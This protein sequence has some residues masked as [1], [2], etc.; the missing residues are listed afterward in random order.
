MQALGLIENEETYLKLIEAYSEKHRY[1]HTSCHIKA[2]LDHL[3]RVNHLADNPQEIEL[4]LWFHDAV[5]KPY[6]STNELDSA[7]WA[8]QFLSENK[9]D[10]ATCERVY[11]LIMVTLHNGKINTSDEELM[12]DIDLSILGSSSIVYQVFEQ[13]V[14][15]EYRWVPYFLYRKKRK[16]ILQGFLDQSKVYQ[17]D[18][19]NGLFEKRARDNIESALLNL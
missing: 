9:V 8:K 10:Q 15:K 5:Y 14:R 6:S 19:F 11:H 2:C 13:N 3:E 12:I 4:A 16:Q 17:T 18:Y 7:I 1:Y